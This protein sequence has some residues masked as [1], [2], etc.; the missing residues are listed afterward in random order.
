MSPEPGVYYVFR[1]RNTASRAF[2]PLKHSPPCK[3]R[4]MQ[5]QKAYF[6]YYINTGKL[7]HIPAES[8]EDRRPGFKLEQCNSKGN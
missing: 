4:E 2:L 8:G 3:T 7:P 1:A 6:L 5:G